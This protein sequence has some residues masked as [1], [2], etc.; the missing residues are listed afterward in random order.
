MQYLTDGNV[1]GMD[2]VV[3][4]I[5]DNLKLF[6]CVDKCPMCVIGHVNLLA[7]DVYLLLVEWALPVMWGMCVRFTTE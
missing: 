2:E 3:V 1:S 5:V 4:L 7:I 6:V